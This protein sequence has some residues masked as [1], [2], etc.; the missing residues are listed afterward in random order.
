MT[1][2]ENPLPHLPM[3]H[4]Q[5]SKPHDMMPFCGNFEPNKQPNQPSGFVA[6][7]GCLLTTILLTILMQD[8]GWKVLN[9]GNDSFSHLRSCETL[10]KR[11]SPIQTTGLPNPR[12]YYRSPGF[13]KVGKVKIGTFPGNSPWSPANPYGKWIFFN[14]WKMGMEIPWISQESWKAQFGMETSHITRRS[15]RDR[16][17]WCAPLPHHP[18]QNTLNF[19][20]LRRGSGFPTIVGN[21]KD[22]HQIKDLRT[23]QVPKWFF[24]VKRSQMHLNLIKFKCFC[25]HLKGS[26][27]LVTYIQQSKYVFFVRHAKTPSDTVAWTWKLSLASSSFM[28]L[29]RKLVDFTTKAREAKLLKAF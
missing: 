20:L 8:F 29:S 28:V 23:V 12:S 3:H 5:L 19:F 16:C 6:A 10:R 17:P 11:P 27:I 21:G 9:W 13:V 24:E 1:D 15:T 7:N 18:P 25:N 14:G 2:S 26:Q 22:R 4:L